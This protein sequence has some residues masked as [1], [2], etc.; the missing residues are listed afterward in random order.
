MTDK[1]KVLGVRLPKTRI[2]ELNR[3]LSEKGISLREYLMSP[4]GAIADEDELGLILKFTGIKRSEFLRQV[5]ELILDGYLDVRGGKVVVKK[6]TRPGYE[7][8][9][10]PKM[11]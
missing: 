4:I 2:E 3:E 5:V 8:G 10:L 9:K 11:Q 1:T 7:A 6:Q